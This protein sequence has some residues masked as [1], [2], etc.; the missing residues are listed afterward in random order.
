MRK[1]LVPVMALGLFALALG[2]HHVAGTCDCEGPADH[3]RFVHYGAAP[4]TVTLPVGGTVKTPEQLK[5]MPMS[6]D[7]K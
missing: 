4:T 3:C 7:K 5:E 2:C 6:V 1:L